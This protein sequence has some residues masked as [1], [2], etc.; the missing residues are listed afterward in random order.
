[1]KDKR[2]GDIARLATLG[3]LLEGKREMARYVMELRE[4]RK[5]ND[6]NRLLDTL[7]LEDLHTSLVIVFITAAGAVRQHLTGWDG[8]ASRVRQHFMYLHGQQWA[9]EHLKGIL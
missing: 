7:P 6:L 3:T 4:P 1:M 2:I 5:L 9:D 8:F